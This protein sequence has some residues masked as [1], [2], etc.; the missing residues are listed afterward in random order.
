MATQILIA[1]DH[2]ILRQG[3][4][5]L[6]HSQGDMTVVGQASD[7]R[8]A[9]ELAQDLRPEIVVMDLGMPGLNGIDATRQILALLP[10]AQV[11]VL[12]AR[13]DRQ[14][15]SEAFRAGAAGYVLK[16]AAMEELVNAIHTVLSGEK[17]LGNK[18]TSSLAAEFLSRGEDHRTA[19]SPR[20]REVLQLLAE[21]KATKEVAMAL[22]VSVKTAETHR[23]SIMEKLNLFSIAELTKHAIREGLT[24]LDY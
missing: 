3:L 19:L 16:D 23:R 14:S 24:S 12:S 1:D 18:M 6:L 15:V 8:K 5:A 22:G 7:G 4:T 2:Q 13:S 10:D 17:Y 9:V 20:E 11:I 21:G